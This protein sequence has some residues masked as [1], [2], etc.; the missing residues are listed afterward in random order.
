MTKNKKTIYLTDEALKKLEILT[1]VNG[2]DNS[3]VIDILLKKV[4]KATL[5]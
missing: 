4:K 2:M 1:N 3:K 5:F